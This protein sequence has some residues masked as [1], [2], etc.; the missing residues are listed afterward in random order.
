MSY[1]NYYMIILYMLVLVCLFVCLFCPWTLNEAMELHTFRTLHKNNKLTGKA[2][3]L[4]ALVVM[5]CL[6]PSSLP[7]PLLSS[8]CSFYCQTHHLK[9][10]TRTKLQNFSYEYFAKAK[11]GRQGIYFFVMLVFH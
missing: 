11:V 3:H 8:S 1:Y 7:S 6:A 5:C 4:E 2:N 10:E 9:K